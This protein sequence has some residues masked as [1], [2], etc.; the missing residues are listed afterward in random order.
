MFDA[1]ADVATIK[2]IGRWHDMKTMLRY[3]H[4]DQVIEQHAVNQ[5][6][7]FLNREPS[8]VLEMKKA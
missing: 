7:E 5:L 1:G 3:C 4:R 8:K 2:K 6:A